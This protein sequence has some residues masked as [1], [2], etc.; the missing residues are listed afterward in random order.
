MYPTKKQ[1]NDTKTF[2]VIRYKDIPRD[3]QKGIDFSKVACTFRP[4]KSDPNRTCIT[5][6]GQNITYPGDVETKTTP[7]QC[8]VLLL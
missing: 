5:I 7:P 8:Y 4:K 1:L 3:R 2:H 6:A